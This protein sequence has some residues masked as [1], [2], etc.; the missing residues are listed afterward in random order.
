MLIAGDVYD[1]A[2]PGVDVVD[3]FPK[4]WSRIRAAGAKVVLTSGNHDSAIRLGFGS[5]SWRTAACMCAPGW[6]NSQTLRW[7]WTAGGAT[8]AVYGIPCL[9][10]RLCA[11]QLGAAAPSHTAVTRA[12][13]DRIHA[14]VAQRKAARARSFRGP[15]AH[16]RQRRDQLGQ[17]AGPEHRR[18]GSGSAGPVRR[19]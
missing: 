5:G 19:F 14:D 1:R 16:V 7:S 17:R 6:T 12:A 18:S 4:R 9:E 2:L 13:T 3:L 10:P 11:D 15:G 8:L